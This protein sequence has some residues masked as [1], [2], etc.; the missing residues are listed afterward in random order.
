ME[1][2][3]TL[4]RYEGPY[5]KLLELINDRKL[6]ITE[7]SL[8]A[9][10]DDYIAYITSCR[11]KDTADMSQFILV[12]STLMLMKAKSL[13]PGIIYTEE[14]ELQVHDLEHKLAVHSLLLESCKQ[15]RLLYG[16][17]PLYE[18][19]RLVY[20]GGPVFVPDERVSSKLLYSV[21][22]LTL[23][24]F[25]MPEKITKVA[26]AHV[27][28]LE[29]V[30][31]RILERVQQASGVLLSSLTESQGS[32]EEKKKTLIVTF[33]ALLELVRKGSIT[34]DQETSSSD[35]ILHRVPQGA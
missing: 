17:N 28:R 34:A 7:I 29:S 24:T 19:E 2:T 21:A 6:S 18:R 32:F 20:K 16:V 31:E 33:I 12:A 8:A 10:A 26:V 22:E 27:V 11:E 30:I 3:V 5:T 4:D 9:V 25:V 15:F 14:E 13:I 23:A 35:I 1:F